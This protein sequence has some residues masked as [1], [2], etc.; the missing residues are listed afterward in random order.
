MSTRKK[1][2]GKKNKHKKKQLAAMIEERKKQGLPFDDL[3][4]PKKTRYDQNGQV[5]F[6]TPFFDE[7]TESDEHQP[8]SLNQILENLFS[9]R[10]LK[11]KLFLINTKRKR[12]HRS[13]KQ[14]AVRVRRSFKKDMTSAI[15][16]AKEA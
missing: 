9:V 1:N 10:R 7:S 13:F 15:Y 5:L 2:E 8:S 16:H 4:K 12:I 6:S 3:L 14:T 11:K